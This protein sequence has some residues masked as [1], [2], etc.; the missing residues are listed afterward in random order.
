M[1]IRPVGFL[2]ITFLYVLFVY[3]VSYRR[4]PITPPLPG[5]SFGIVL[6]RGRRIA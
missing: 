3:P 6:Q 2:A 1:Q 4:G 5:T